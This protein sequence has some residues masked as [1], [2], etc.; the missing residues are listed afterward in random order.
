[1]SAQRLRLRSALWTSATCMEIDFGADAPSVHIS[2]R[3]FPMLGLDSPVVT[4]YYIPRSGCSDGVMGMPGHV[5]LGT[6]V[7][8]A[9]VSAVRFTSYHSSSGAVIGHKLA[10]VDGG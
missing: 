1:M 3:F 8:Q 6:T 2:H 5:S 4:S 9:L 7:S 10:L